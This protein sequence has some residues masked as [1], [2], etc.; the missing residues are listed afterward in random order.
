LIN[1]INQA[2]TGVARINK[3]GEVGHDQQYKRDFTV[4]KS[5]K[6]PRGQTQLNRII[7]RTI[8]VLF[9]GLES[10]TV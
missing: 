5:Q 7:N 3:V 9:R 2:D 1:W 4:P 6:G 8:S 10:Y